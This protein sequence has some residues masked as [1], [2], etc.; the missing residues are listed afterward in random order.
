GKRD[1]KRGGKNGEQGE[2]HGWLL[3]LSGIVPRGGVTA[4][5]PQPLERSGRAPALFR[6]AF[7]QKPLTGACK[8]FIICG[9]RSVQLS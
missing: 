6:G 9:R 2:Q 8:T 1:N 3:S 7:S 4:G 5:F